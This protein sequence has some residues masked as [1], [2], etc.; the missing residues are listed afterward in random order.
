MQT[1][2]LQVTGSQKKVIQTIAKGM[3]IPIVLSPEEEEILEDR[4]LVKL[5]KSRLNDP[6]LSKEETEEFRKSLRK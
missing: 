4:A 6:V 3:K 1:I 2:T 5:M